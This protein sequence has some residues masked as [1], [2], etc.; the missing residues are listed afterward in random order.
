MSKLLDQFNKLQLKEMPDVKPGYTI[1]V[2]Q[3][4]KEG[5]KERIQIFE[6]IVI[7]RKHGKGITSTVTVRKVTDGIGIERIFPVHSPAIEKIEVIKKGK[8][9][10]SKLYYLRTAKG[11]KSRLKNKEFA[12]AI[13]PDKTVVEETLGEIDLETTATKITED[14]TAKE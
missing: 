10:R 4:I 7:A 5:D 1:K 9:R 12:E 11:R 2:H 13:A 6:G 8:A 14:S 3:K